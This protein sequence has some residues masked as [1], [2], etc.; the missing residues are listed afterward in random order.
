[1]FW[2]LQLHANHR[3]AK[4]NMCIQ[5]PRVVYAVRSGFAMRN[6]Q[7]AL[8]RQRPHDRS[9]GINVADGHVSCPSCHP[10]RSRQPRNF[11][12]PQQAAWLTNSM[13]LILCA[14][15]LISGFLVTGGRPVWFDQPSNQNRMTLRTDPPDEPRPPHH[16]GIPWI[17]DR[18]SVLQTCSIC[19]HVEMRL[20]CVCIQFMELTL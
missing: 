13:G 6:S 14:Y 20:V 5:L 9:R 3:W 12:P 2:S 19:S 7:Q 15:P 10:G 16:I 1:M 11:S 8:L 17:L 18:G 4:E